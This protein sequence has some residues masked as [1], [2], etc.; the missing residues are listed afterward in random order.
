[1]TYKTTNSVEYGP[2]HEADFCIVGH[3]I[4]HKPKIHDCVDK[5]LVSV[6]V[7]SQYDPFCPIPI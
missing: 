6:P 7:L 1:M 5:N 4:S 3:R 2:S